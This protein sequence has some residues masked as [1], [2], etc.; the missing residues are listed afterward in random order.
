MKVI[1]TTGLH[2]FPYRLE[3][4]KRSGCMEELT[5]VYE[6]KSMDTIRRHLKR[7]VKEIEIGEELV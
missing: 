1:V 6:S 5:D 4:W 7:Y 2:G 3:V